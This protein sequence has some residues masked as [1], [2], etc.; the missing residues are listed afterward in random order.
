M[1]DPTMATTSTS[2]AQS[3]PEPSGRP[4]GQMERVLK[5]FYAPSQ[6]FADLRRSTSWWLPF[7]LMVV[8]TLA[9]SFAAGSKIGWQQIADNNQKLMSQKQQERMQEQMEKAPPEQR[10]QTQRMMVMV[11]KG[12][13]YAFP[14]AILIILVIFAAI[15]MAVMNFG[16]GAEIKFSEV[17]AVIMFSGVVRVIWAILVIIGIFTFI[18]PADFLMQMPIATNP[19]L[20]FNINVADHR[21]LF[22]FLA[23]FDIFALW[24]TALT[25]I[26]FKTL[27]KKSMGACM[28]V[29]FGVLIAFALLT[30]L[31]SLM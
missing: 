2:A 29:A 21:F 30:S 20:L 3:F 9:M 31:P 1:S 14:V 24:A 15:Y 27:S 10:A 26:G 8:C 23:N 19:S 4:M 5:M 16:L 6:T 28:A 12:I 17:F 11:T 25:G 7:V 13:A 22:T 18:D